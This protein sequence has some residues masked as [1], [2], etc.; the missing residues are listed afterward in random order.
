MPELPEVESIRLG[1][2]QVRG[3]RIERVEVRH[4]RPVRHHITGPAGFAADLTGRTLLAARRRGKYLWFALDGD[5]ALMVHFGMSGQFRINAP[6]DDL[7][8]NTRVVF[9]LDD[10]SQLRFVDQRMFGGLQFSPGGAALPD[11]VVHIAPDPFELV[12]DI[13]QV[14]ARIATSPRA[15][16]RLLLDQQVVSGFG[17]IYADET[18]WQCRLHG[19]RPGASLRRAGALRLLQTGT[20]VMAEALRAGGT[21]FDVLYVHVNGE[22]GYFDRSLHVYGREGQPCDRCGRPIVREPFMN[23]SSFRCPKCQRLR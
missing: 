23:R 13:E 3:R 5:D 19:E 1:L 8:P 15:V 2:E 16:K 6:D 21:S 14:A 12:F 4:P 10:A 17:N 18:L 11:Q 20:E 7:L 9:D 22:S